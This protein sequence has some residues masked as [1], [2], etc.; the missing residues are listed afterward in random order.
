ME[1]QICTALSGIASRL[2]NGITAESGNMI[3]Q[4][5][6]GSGKTVF[7]TNFIKAL[8]QMT[9]KPSGKIGK[10]EAEVLNKKDIEKLFSK[11]SGGCLIVESVGG[12]SADAAERL[13]HLLEND[14]QGTLVIVE[15]TKHGIENALAKSKAFASKFTERIVIPIFTNDELVVFAKSYAK[16]HGYRID[17][18]GI[19]ALY[20]SISNIQKLDKATTIA[21]VKEIV[22]EAIVH[23]ETGAIK[24]A[25]SILTSSRFDKEDY[26]IL[27]EK[28]FNI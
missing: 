11:V 1:E 4:G 8:Q 20:N 10:V 6:S 12:L 26:V 24:K 14:K 17:E 3:V 27:H 21:E 28:D 7:A 18:M 2:A 22:D 23:V 16:E 9:G 15:D 13:A 5:G 25:F 19:L